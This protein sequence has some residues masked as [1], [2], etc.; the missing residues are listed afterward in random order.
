M[1][2]ALLIA[3]SR[4]EASEEIV[5]G[6]NEGIQ[7][8][9]FEYVVTGYRIQKKISE[10]DKAL[11]AKGNFYIVTFK[12]VNNA[13]RVKHEWDNSIAYLV[14]DSG[15]KYE[16]DSTAQITLDNQ[17]AFGWRDHYVTEHQESQSTKFIFD[18]PASVKKPFLM[19]RGSTLMGDFLDSG[20]FEKTKVKLF[21]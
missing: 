9:D 21:E 12:T 11:V 20:E 15:N 6:M 4:K 16:N 8:D 14:D 3:C 17:E 7:H 1:F 18:L 13:K 5:I 2:L 10:G 19:V